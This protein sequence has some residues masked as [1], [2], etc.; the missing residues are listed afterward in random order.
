MSFKLHKKFIDILELLFFEMSHDLPMYFL[1]S[2]NVKCHMQIYKIIMCVFQNNHDQNIIEG[3]IRTDIMIKDK[4][5]YCK[6]RTMRM[7][8]L[9]KYVIFL[10]YKIITFIKAYLQQKAEKMLATPTRLLIPQNDDVLSN[11][12]HEYSH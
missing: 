12:E 1:V 3:Y 4:K 7:P 5:Y 6:N 10:L 9:S 2:Y 11:K 8:L